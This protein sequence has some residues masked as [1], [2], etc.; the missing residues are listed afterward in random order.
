MA[1]KQHLVLNSFHNG[2]NTKIN[3]RDIADDN[4]AISDNIS[5]DDVGRLTMSGKPVIVSLSSEPTVASL[6]DGYSLFRFSSDY[7]TSTS[8]SVA[9]G[10][11]LADTDYIILW[12]DTLGK[13]YWLPGTTTWET[14]S[15]LDLSNNNQWGTTQAALPMFYYV[16]GALR[17]SDGNFT[18]TNN[19]PQWIGTINRTL[20]PDAT[21]V[22]ISGWQREKQELEKPTVGTIS[23]VTTAPPSTGIHWIVNNL[24]PEDQLYDFSDAEDAD[25]AGTTSGDTDNNLYSVTKGITYAEGLG[26]EQISPEHWQTSRK[27]TDGYGSSNYHAFAMAFHGENDDH[28]NNFTWTGLNATTFN[29]GGSSKTFS[30]GQSIYAA[31][32]L[33]GDEN[34]DFWTGSHVRNLSGEASISLSIA[35]ASIKFKDNTSS[36]YIKFKIDH[37]KF[38]DATTPSALKCN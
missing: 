28:S 25:G 6:T 17:I 38:T 32:R 37:T 4:L 5:V 7:N 11:I 29:L 23:S 20:F 36:N 8:G 13:L 14:I 1:G 33:P 22:A 30:T 9:A 15:A 34:Q 21:T 35:D 19:A 26:D 2:L 27:E 10:S 18:N 12:N 31:V 16:D 24:K 3:S